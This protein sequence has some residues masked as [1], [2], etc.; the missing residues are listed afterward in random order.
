[1]GSKLPELSSFKLSAGTGKAAVFQEV[2]CVTDP[3]MEACTWSIAAAP[4]TTQ[5]IFTQSPMD[6]ITLSLILGGPPSPSVTLVTAAPR[7]GAKLQWAEASHSR[8]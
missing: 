8:P 2:I 6:L 1:M 4:L 5:L 3:V 7:G